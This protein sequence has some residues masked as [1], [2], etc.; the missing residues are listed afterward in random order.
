MQCNTVAR[1][2][3]ALYAGTM[4]VKYTHADRNGVHAATT[5]RYMQA[6][7]A[8][9]LVGE[10]HTDHIG[11]HVATLSSRAVHFLAGRML[12]IHTRQRHASA[13]HMQHG[14]YCSMATQCD[15]AYTRR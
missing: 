2:P 10:V 12:Y 1:P 13:M 15:G 7:N 8:D 9:A 14:R 3:G 11:R 6:R 5:I 4:T